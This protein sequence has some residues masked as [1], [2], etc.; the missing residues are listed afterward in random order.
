MKHQLLALCAGTLFFVACNNDKK[1]DDS[2]GGVRSETVS[3]SD[4]GDIKAP[5]PGNMDTTGAA[6][7]WAT[8]MT[9]GDMQK[10]LAKGAGTWEGEVHSYMPGAPVDTQKGKEVTRMSMNGLYQESDFSSTMMGQPFMGR[11]TM[12]YDNIRNVFVSTWI[13]NMGSGIILM[14]GT[15]DAATKTL[16]MKG[17]QTDPTYGTQTDMRQ[18]TIFTDDDNYTMNMYNTGPD[19]KEMKVMDVMLKRKK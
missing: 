18:E 15:Y 4:K 14:E 3:A 5:E 13:D 1:G 16:N 19:G 9:P 2:K 7:R 11:S 10:W 6:Q 12:G 17:K 8:Y